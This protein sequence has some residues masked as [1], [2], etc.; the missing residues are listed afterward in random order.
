MKKNIFLV[1]ILF[2]LTGCTANYEIEIN[3][4]KIKE[5]LTVLENNVELFDK[6]ND[7]GWTLRDSF[8]AILSRDEFSKDDYS[9]ESLNNKNQ[10]GFKYNNEK[11]E[12]IINSTILNQCYTNPSVKIKNNIVEIQTGDSFECYELYENLESVKVTFKTNHKV[13]STNADLKQDNK[14]IWNITEKG[15]KNI[16][17]SYDNSKKN[18]DFNIYIYIVV[19]GLVLIILLSIISKKIITKNRF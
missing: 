11:L 16:K 1:L 7:S 3:N 6:E 2:V 18:T 4:N 19:G 5:K 17:I 8:N 9:I 14:Y 15:N 10:L 13:I 12:S